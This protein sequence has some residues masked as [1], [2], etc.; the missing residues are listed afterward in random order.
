MMLIQVRAVISSWFPF[1]EALGVSEE[2]LKQVQE[3][4]MEDYDKL[5]EVLDYWFRTFP[6]NTHPTWRTVAMALQNVG[7]GSLSTDIM[8][9]YTTGKVYR[10]KK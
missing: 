10:L 8:K 6:K 1:G 5:V 2:Y 7:F 4:N 3:M 9:V